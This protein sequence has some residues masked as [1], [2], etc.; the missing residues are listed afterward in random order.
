MIMK[1]VRK[2]KNDRKNFNWFSAETERSLHS[3][4]QIYSIKYF[5]V[6]FVLPNSGSNYQG[7]ERMP[8]ERLHA[9]YRVKAT[10]QPSK[11]L[12]KI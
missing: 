4:R 8:R 7:H 2:N 11:E 6:K 9:T 5:I 12:G 3:F 1:F 10:I